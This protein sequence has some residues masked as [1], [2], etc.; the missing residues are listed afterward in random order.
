MLEQF[1]ITGDIEDI[2]LELFERGKTKQEAI[3]VVLQKYP[4]HRQEAETLWDQWETRYSK[5]S[6]LFG[7]D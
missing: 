1:I 3:A 6:N 5:V 2:L 4:D 7:I